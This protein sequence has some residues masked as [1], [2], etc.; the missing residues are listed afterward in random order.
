MLYAREYGRSDKGKIIRE[1]ANQKYLSD[2]H[3]RLLQRARSII[4]YYKSKDSSPTE[5]AI[6]TYKLKKAYGEWHSLLLF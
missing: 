5:Y 4:N 3:N 2:P 6:K 1:K